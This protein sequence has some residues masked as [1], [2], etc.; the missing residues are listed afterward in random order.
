[1]GG[2]ADRDSRSAL[3]RLA[4]LLLVLA[5]AGCATRTAPT[6]AGIHHVVRRGENL[7]RIGKAYGIGYRELARRNGIADP[8]KIVVGQRIFVPGATRLLPVEIITPRSVETSPVDRDLDGRGGGPFTWP[9]RGGRVVSG[10]GPRGGSFHDGIDVAAPEGT[11]IYAA[12]AGRVIY[13]DQLRGYGKV[14]IV[15]HEGEWVTLYAHNSRNAVR[16]GDRVSTGTL[17]GEVG[18]TGR[19]TGP[20]LHFEIRRRNAA[21]DPLRYLPPR[22]VVG[23][24]R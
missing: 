11:P 6:G 22:S 23:A 19:A 17:L 20:N 3:F 8:S 7:F 15:E 1:M 9:I 4:A 10:F 2:S 18:R 13:S 14:V 12:G 5:F 16:E 24:A 21:R